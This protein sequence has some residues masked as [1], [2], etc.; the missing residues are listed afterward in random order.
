MRRRT[1]FWTLLAVILPLAGLLPAYA[2]GDQAVHDA[3][4]NVDDTGFSPATV[5]IVAGGSVTWVEKGFFVHTA[6]SL[7]GAPQTFSTGGIGP[8]GSVSL[9]FSTPGTYGYTSATDC[10]NGNNMP[11]FNCGAV[12]TVVV[13]PP[14]APFANATPIPFGVTPTPAPALPNATVTITDHGVTPATI[15]VPVDGVV[16]WVNNGSVVHTATTNG[17]APLAFDSGG[18]APG[19]SVALAMPLPGSYMYSSATDCMHGNS[20]PGFNCGPYTVTVV[21]S[22]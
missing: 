7:G 12:Y 16:T 6:T 21:A 11:R 22:K 4:V 14:G 18:L 1:L 13:E 8:F 10:L 3:V 15:T 19:Q 2:A 20:N 17:Q 5:T 9:T